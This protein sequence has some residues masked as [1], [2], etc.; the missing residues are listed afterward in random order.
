MTKPFI[1][2]MGS[3]VFGGSVAKHTNMLTHW[4]RSVCGCGRFVDKWRCLG[5]WLPSWLVG[6]VVDIKY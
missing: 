3:P 1:K 4:I 2:L 5:S 6:V